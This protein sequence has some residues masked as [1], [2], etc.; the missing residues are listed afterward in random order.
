[1]TKLTVY[2][3]G[4]GRRQFEPPAGPTDG[5]GDGGN[6]E[7]RIARLETKMDKVDE[8]LGKLEIGVAVLTERVGHLPSKGFIVTATTSAIAFVVAV[9]LLADKIKTLIG[10]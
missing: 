4:G 3:G 1:M 10:I 8:R 2:D 9:I 7:A 6:L 5:N